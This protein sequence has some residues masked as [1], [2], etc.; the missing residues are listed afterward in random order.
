MNKETLTKLERLKNTLRGMEKL[1][2]AFSGGVDSTFLLRVAQEVLG[3]NVMAVIAS[4]ETYPDK[5]IQDAVSLV[6]NWNVRYKVI[7]TQE[8]ENPDFVS[9]PPQ[10][11]YFCKKELF[12][13][14]KEIAVREGIP[15]VADGANFED[16][17]DFRPGLQAGKE[18]NVRSPLKESFLLK[19][20]IREL[21]QEM[22]VPTWNKPSLACL[23]S[24]FPYYTEIDKKS[25]VQIAQAEEYLKSMGFAQVR[26][27][28]HGQIAR[29]EVEPDEILKAAGTEKRNRIVEKFKKI[30]YSYVT[31]DLAGYRTGSMNEPLPSDIKGK[32]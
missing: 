27:R 1:L 24:R 30:G 12:T 31:I 3:E 11:C 25:L 14:L 19:S 4:S 10:R 16:M 9:N 20:E 23:S 8:L 22:G 17:D 6:K 21:S 29:I 15:Y 26:V 5:E 28:H 18:L 7:Q 2:I 13:K 32:T